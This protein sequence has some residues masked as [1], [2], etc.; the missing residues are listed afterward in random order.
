MMMMV[1]SRAQ[2][3][4]EEE[5]EEKK[6][7][8]LSHIFKIFF[9]K[10]RRFKSKIKLHARLSLNS[11]DALSNLSSAVHVRR[12]AL[13]GENRKSILHVDSI[14]CPQDAIV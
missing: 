4:E 9:C 5:E 10:E 13:A 11:R 6:N 1:V 12:N 14:D 7:F 8:F 2:R 3:R